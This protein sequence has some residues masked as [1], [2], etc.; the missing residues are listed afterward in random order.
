MF[1]KEVDMKISENYEDMYFGGT[2]MKWP[3]F[4]KN[5]HVKITKLIGKS[6]N[7]EIECESLLRDNDV[8]N[9]KL[10]YLLQILLQNVMNI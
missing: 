7:I 8:N 10:R 1:I 9:F 6:G 3:S 2:F 4:S 5:P